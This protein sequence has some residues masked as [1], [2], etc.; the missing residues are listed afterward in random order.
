MVVLFSSV[1]GVEP[2]S[3]TV[4]KQ[5][6]KYKI[7]RIAYINKMDR[8]GANFLKVC[9]DIKNIFNIHP[10][11][12]QL[13]LIK[14]D[15]FIGV[16]D[17]IYKKQIIWENK[18]Y[19]M[20]YKEVEIPSNMD[21]II[22]KY[23]NKILETLSEY[24]DEIMNKFLSK[25]IIKEKKIIKIIKKETCKMNIVPIFCGSSFKNKGVQKILD[26]ICMYLPSPLN[27]KK[28][29]GKNL[30]NKKKIYI[31]PK[32]NNFFCSLVFKISTDKFVGKLVF[33]RVYS[34]KLKL[35]DFVYNPRTKKKE[36]ISRMYQMHANKQI[37]IKKILA[38]DI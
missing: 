24:D 1:E 38:G 37:P 19:G 17:L 30:L 10:I 16:I 22:K 11:I 8:K 23:E 5:A 2:Q 33:I 13:P 31:V 7:P 21:S 34:G 9:K 29:K 20:K 15:K 26:A 12:L 18:N 4:W 25:K 14:N 35:G 36:K 27:Y 28:I 3:E 32:Y 6:N